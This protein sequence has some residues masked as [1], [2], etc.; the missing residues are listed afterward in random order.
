MLREAVQ[1]LR[2][3][4]NCAGLDLLDRYYAGRTEY[5]DLDRKLFAALEAEDTLLMADIVEHGMLEEA[6]A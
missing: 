3:G 5:T 4:E 2:V 6:N 1:H